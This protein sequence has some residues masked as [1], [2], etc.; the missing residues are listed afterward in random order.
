MIPVKLD[1]RI[2]KKIKP[3]KDINSI[4]ILTI[5][6][7]ESYDPAWFRHVPLDIKAFKE[8]EKSFKGFKWGLKKI[9]LDID[10]VRQ[11]L[12]KGKTPWKDDAEKE[13]IVIN[14]QK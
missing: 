12:L 2:V 3:D 6:S 10:E 9:G 7:E 11:R 13:Q 8:K 14:C 5:P 4:Q 1:A